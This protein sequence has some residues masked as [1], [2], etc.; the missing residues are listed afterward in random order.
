MALISIEEARDHCRTD[1]VD[2]AMLTLYSRTAER[3]AMQFLNRNVYEDGAALAAALAAV[4][5]MAS[6]AELALET[7]KEAAEAL[8]GD[9]KAAALRQAE[10]AY[11]DAQETMRATE[12]GM[13]IV[14]DVKVGMLLILG[15]L[16]RTRETVTQESANAVPMGAHS[17]LWPYRVGLGV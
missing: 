17:F 10:R 5:T 14:E 4:P 6:A 3:A 7:A 13:V 8:E 16:Y 12:A 15:H 2:D 1:D 9:A 11:A